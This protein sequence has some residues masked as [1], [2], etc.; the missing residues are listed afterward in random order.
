M[1]HKAPQQASLLWASGRTSASSQAERCCAGTKAN[2]NNEDQE[3]KTSQLEM[4]QC[5]KV[6]MHN[7]RVGRPVLGFI[8]P[9]EVQDLAVQEDSRGSHYPAAKWFVQRTRSE[10]KTRLSFW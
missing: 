10:K 5:S 6:Q 7:Y 2:G 3:Q 8:R 4:N 9:G 1:Y